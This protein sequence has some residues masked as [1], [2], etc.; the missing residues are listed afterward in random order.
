MTTL[1]LVIDHP[2]AAPER[3]GILSGPALIAW[4]KFGAAIYAEIE[5]S[6]MADDAFWQMAVNAGLGQMVPD[7]AY[8]PEFLM[9]ERA[10]AA[11]DSLLGLGGGM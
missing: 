4:A 8:G 1:P 10:G 11:M 6:G 5:D 3:G 9:S 7:E 2:T